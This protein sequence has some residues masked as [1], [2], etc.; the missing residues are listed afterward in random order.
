MSAPCVNIVPQELPG[1]LYAYVAEAL[2]ARL[3]EKKNRY[4]KD[5]LIKCEEFIDKL[6]SMKKRIYEE[7]FESSNRNELLAELKKFREDNQ[8]LIKD[9]STIWWCRIKDKKQRRKICKRGVM[10]IPSTGRN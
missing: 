4:D 6:V 1:D 9:C 8:V 10:T 7:G 2:W 3:E 5:R